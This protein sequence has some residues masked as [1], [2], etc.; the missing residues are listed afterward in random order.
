MI[1]REFESS[2]S[3]IYPRE[4]TISQDKVNGLLEFVASLTTLRSLKYK[5]SED[6]TIHSVLR[7]QLRYEVIV[8]DNRINRLSSVAQALLQSG[9]AS[10]EP[11]KRYNNGTFWSP[12]QWFD[13]IGKNDTGERTSSTVPLS[14]VEEIFAVLVSSMEDGLRADGIAASELRGVL[15][16]GASIRFRLQE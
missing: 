4:V 7:D 13:V 5:M 8:L 2:E 12:P 6:D 15:Q 3:I 9:S 16:H 11:D 1:N 10:I 14:A